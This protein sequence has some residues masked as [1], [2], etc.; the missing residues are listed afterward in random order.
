MPA[1]PDDWRR[2]GQEDYLRGAR[3][4]WK[5]Y[6]ALSAQW[7]HEHCEFC[8]QKFLDAEYSP[9]HRRALEERSDDIE[10]AGYTNLAAGDVPAGKWWICKRCFED[11]ADEIEWVVVESDPDAWPYG[12]HEPDQ[13]PTAEDYVPPEGQWLPRPE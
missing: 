5:R 1:A 6:Q 12:A 9:E 7:E 8:W 3:L 13:R 11:F 10:P 2:Q 4:T